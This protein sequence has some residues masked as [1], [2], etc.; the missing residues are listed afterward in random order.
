[1]IG[2]VHGVTMFNG[3]GFEQRSSKRTKHLLFSDGFK[4]GCHILTLELRFKIKIS[5]D[6]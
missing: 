6:D 2:C 3:L 1:M 5:N 4:Q